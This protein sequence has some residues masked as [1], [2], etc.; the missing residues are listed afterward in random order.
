MGAYAQ[1]IWRCRYFWFSLVKMDLRTRYRRS[2]LGMGWS[3]L[4]PIA[5]TAVLC[6]VFHKIFHQDIRTYAPFLLSGMAC[7]QYIVNVGL[8]GCECMHQGE[9]YIR[10]FP[11]PLAIYPLRTAL[12]AA[13]HFFIALGIVLAFSM[14]VGG[15]SNPRALLSIVPSVVLLLVFGWSMA[16]LFGLANVFF[17]DTKHLSEVGFQLL[18][19]GTPVMYTTK[20]LGEGSKIAWLVQHNP[21]GAFLH[22]IREPILEGRVPALST[23]A[24]AGGLTLILAII[25][26]MA[27]ARFQRRL[28]FFL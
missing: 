2:F 3:L 1:G 10:Q 26:A 4:H 15:K 21:L 14:I 25:A 6:F 11:A 18:F 9:S 12:G 22:L 16:T 28:I 23:Y 19:Y 8:Q 13:I 27:L 24:M 20:F 5:M 17:Q 7:W